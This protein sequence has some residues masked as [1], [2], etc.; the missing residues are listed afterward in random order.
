LFADWWAGRQVAGLLQGVQDPLGV[1]LE[2]LAGQA[3]LLGAPGNAAVGS[4]EDG[5]GIGDP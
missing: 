1:A 2:G 3:L 4:V 5:G